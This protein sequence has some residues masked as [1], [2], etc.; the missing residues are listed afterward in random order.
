MRWGA[1]NKVEFEVSKTEALIFSRRRKVLQA[2]K[3]ATISI[4]GK[5]FAI[6]QG[7][8]KW[9]GFW[10]DLKPSF[11]MHFDNKIARPVN[12]QTVRLT[13]LICFDWLNIG[14]CLVCLAD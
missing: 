12:S 11:K 9:L 8:T 6:K 5:T 14:N 1:D 2:A 10:L 7:A 4:G 13:R 3:D